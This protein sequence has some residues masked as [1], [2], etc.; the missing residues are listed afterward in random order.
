[1]V[2][3]ETICAGQS[4]TLTANGANAYAWSTG[5]TGNSISVSPS[6]TTTFTL[7]GTTTGCVSDAVSATVT[8][9]KVPTVL[10]NS[11][12]ICAGQS[13][14]LTASGA[15]AYA[16]STGETGNSISVSPSATTTFTLT[17]TTAGCVSDPV[18][19]IVT[20]NALPIIDLGADIVLQQGQQAVLNANSTDLIYLWSSG[21]STPSIVVNVAG[22]YSVTVTNAAGCSA[23]D[24]VLVEIIS[25]TNDPRTRYHIL[26]APNPVLDILLVTCTGSSTSS[27]QVIDNLGRVLVQD[28]TFEV[29]GATRRL[30]L[31]ALPA[32]VYYLRMSSDT[33]IQ[34]IPIIKH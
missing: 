6:E 19:A 30:S 27:A 11:E 8:V 26:V 24:S 21:E 17:G 4:A 2:N 3:S 34:T 28:N 14:T 9:N 20:V 5:E 18:S 7:T 10:V 33:F 25:A 31:A 29:D 15:N 23:T 22:T 32:G 12:T 13:A 16:W 1:L